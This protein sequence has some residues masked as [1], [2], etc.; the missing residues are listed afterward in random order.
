M[1]SKLLLFSLILLFSLPS[2]FPLLHAGFFQTDDGEWMVIRFSAF[3]QAFADG[4]FPVRWLGRL[5]Y[6]YGYPVATFLYPGFM[7]LGIPIKFIGFGFVDTIK[8]ILDISM[9]G[10]AIFSYLWLR[11]FFGAFAA[12]IGA[13][14]YLYAPYHL[15]DLYV[16]G[17]V[18]EILVLA[19]VPFILWQIE[20]KNIFWGSIGI[21]I[22]ILSHN[23]LALLFLPLILLYM[24]LGI[25]IAVKNGKELVRQYITILVFGIG[26]AAFFWIP[27]IYDLQYTVFSQIKISEW[28][29]Y[30]AFDQTKFLGYL[31]VLYLAAMLI[32]ARTVRAYLEKTTERLR[33]LFLLFIISTLISLFLNHSV[34]GLV[35]QL[36]PISFIQF[37]FRLLSIEILGVSFIA[38]FLISFLSGRKQYIASAVLFLLLVFPS[39]FFLKPLQ[40]FDKGEGFYATNMDT[41]TVKNEYMPKWVKEPP[42]QRPEQKVEIIKGEGAIHNINFDN[43]QITFTANL[44]K[45]AVIRVNA[46][47]WPGWKGYINGKEV[48]VNFENKKGV[49]E[50]PAGIGNHFVAFSLHETA[51]RMFANFIS[52]VSL[53]FLVLL[54]L[55]PRSFQKRV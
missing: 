22:L 38:T 34:S 7:Y 39:V 36:L 26:L 11:R 17:S 20:R 25:Y 43:E 48:G 27:A 50:F 21:G 18:G 49:M 6:E 10:S 51:V 30:F 19:I 8:I 14:V 9:L 29:K 24:L 5:N 13:L 4:Q 35:W 42:T 32:F 2:I 12:V 31:I 44:V 45:D 41:T 46:I 16:R 47:Y 55:F 54:Y 52:V 15:Y 1:K 28:Q 3:Y 37:P 40:F 23:S 53:L 33:S